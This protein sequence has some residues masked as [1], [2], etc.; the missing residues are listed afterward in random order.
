MFPTPPVNGFQP[1]FAF[2]M[3]SAMMRV[4]GVKRSWEIKNAVS[5]C[6]KE[7]VVE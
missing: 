6:P 5:G 2:L 7:L 4:T 1:G 3:L